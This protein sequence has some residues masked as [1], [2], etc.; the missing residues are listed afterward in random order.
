MA[1]I[2]AHTG[3]IFGRTPGA[4]EISATIGGKTVRRTLNVAKPPIRINEIFTNGD[5]PG[6][7]VELVNPSDFDIDLGGWSLSASRVFATVILP[8]GLIIPAHGYRLI[9]ESN[10][11]EGLAASDAV[12]LFSRFGVQVDAF[13][14]LGD[15]QLD[16]SRCP[17]ID[18]PFVVSVPTRRLP[19]A[20]SRE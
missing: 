15:P 10:F 13:S 1:G 6:G 12:H 5:L 8:A 16:D 20:C 4:T 17:E 14:F 19:N 18:G 2:N 9:F 7:F 3:E 11:P